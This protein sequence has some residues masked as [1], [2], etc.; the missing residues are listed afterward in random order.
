MPTTAK[1][2]SKMKS[3]YANLVR[4]NLPSCKRVNAEELANCV[5]HELADREIT[6]DELER[7]LVISYYELEELHAESNTTINE[8]A[9]WV[10]EG[11]KQYESWLEEW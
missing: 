2:E 7:E 10:K 11:I 4:W 6:G 9:R 5:G 3:F 8:W 1:G